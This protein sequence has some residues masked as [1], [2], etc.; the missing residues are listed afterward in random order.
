MRRLLPVLLILSSTILPA[1]ARPA[2]AQS[3]QTV[4]SFAG[5]DGQ[6]PFANLIRDAKGSFYGTTSKGGANDLGAVFRMDAAGNETALYSFRGGTD[7]A[8][9]EQALALDSKGNL[10]GTT[11]NGGNTGCYEELGCGVVFKINSAGKET[12]LYAFSGYSDGAHPDSTL[13]I[14]AQGNVYGTT[15]DGGTGYESSGGGVIFKIDPSG[16]ETV[17]YAFTKG[18][19]GGAPSGQIVRDEEGN[20]YGTTQFAGNSNFC[21]GGGCGTVYKFNVS[22]LALTSLYSFQG[23]PNDGQMPLGGVIRDSAG[24]LY[25]STYQGGSDDAGVVFVVSPS[26]KE[27]VLYAFTG[28]ADGSELVGSLIRDAH[29]NLY[30][31]AASGGLRQCFGGLEGC[32]TVYKVDPSGNETTLYT[33]T[34]GSD[35]GSPQAGL[36][37]DGKG[38]AYGTTYVGGNTG[39]CGE[40]DGCGVIFKITP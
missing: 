26:G 3:V 16:H 33:F 15:Y 35:G 14:D 10:Y 20:I 25:G 29:G 31:T 23:F 27:M 1:T 8:Y 22:S 18:T 37:E 21:Y 28:E 32:G 2:A 13:L 38:N 19:D 39:M 40:P 4:H 11:Q 7:G 6:F 36:M 17:L 9:P 24:N 5:P 12:I 34:G 30:G